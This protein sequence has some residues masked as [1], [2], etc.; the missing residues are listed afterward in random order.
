MK[1]FSIS[2]EFGQCSKGRSDGDQ[3]CIQWLVKQMLLV[4]I[5]RTQMTH[6]LKDSTHKMEGQ[7][8]KKEISWVLGSYIRI[9]IGL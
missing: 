3:S 1:P 6:I 7:P 2:I 4:P 9:M 5:P 8:P